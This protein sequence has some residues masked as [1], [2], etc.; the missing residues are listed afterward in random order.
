VA[1][2]LLKES[3]YREDT[4]GFDAELRFF[5]DLEGREVDFVQLLDR[6]PVRFV[7]CKLNDLEVD[8]SLRYL[9]NKFPGVEAVQVVNRP[10][11]D[12][13][14]AAGIRVVSADR[15]LAELAL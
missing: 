13:I 4:E 1:F 9:A 15:F 6:K 7:E 11:I 14:A 3:H 10:R 8:P 5:R 12:R 2:H